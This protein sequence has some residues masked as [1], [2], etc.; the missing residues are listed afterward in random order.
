MLNR[1]IQAAKHIAPK[2]VTGHADHKQII[3]PL[4]ED[5]F[6]R[7]ARIRAPDDSGEWPLPRYLVD[8]GIK[9]EIARVYF[10]DTAR[11][12]GI[13]GQATQ[14]RCELPITSIQATSSRVSIQ[15][16]RQHRAI[17]GSISVGDLDRSH[18]GC[19]SFP[20]DR[21]LVRDSGLATSYG[22]AAELPEYSITPI[23]P[24]TV[25]SIPRSSARGRGCHSTL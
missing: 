1:V 18:V 17:R 2:A 9:T 3:R 14:Q 7:H 23:S 22:T 13:G 10:H 20:G 21:L 6:D 11:D 5:Q 15:W 12:G 25:R 4:I 19:T 8:V 16:P 24:A